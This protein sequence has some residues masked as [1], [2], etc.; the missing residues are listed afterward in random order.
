MKDNIKCYIGALYMTAVM[1]AVAWLI[2]LIIAARVGDGTSQ[3]FFTCN[4]L[5][6]MEVPVDGVAIGIA[7][8]LVF[9]FF[10]KWVREQN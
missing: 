5:T 9:S 4:S 3:V 6:S 8:S 10:Y 2:W 1:S 7:F